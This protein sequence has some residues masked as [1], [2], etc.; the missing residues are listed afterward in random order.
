MTG[1]T[2]RLIPDSELG[3][4]GNVF[5]AAPA[6]EVDV[7]KSDQLA[8]GLREHL[9]LECETGVPIPLTWVSE[10]EV[11]DPILVDSSRGDQDVEML[12]GQVGIRVET[13]GE[14]T[15][16]HAL[17]KDIGALLAREYE[18]D[19]ERVLRNYVSPDTD[20]IE[21][22]GPG[23][24]LAQQITEEHQAVDLDVVL[25]EQRAAAV[26]EARAAVAAQAEASAGS[27]GR[28]EEW[29]V[30][31]GGLFDRLHIPRHAH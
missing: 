3:H 17:A 10:T 27:P 9:G 23:Y 31:L 26:A 18:D 25:A 20:E 4:E 22:T 19:T 16:D 11:V 12:G 8:S 29:K 13:G 2:I 6:S 28:V 1:A 21:L 30:A 14:G 15:V 24:N 5:I 7:M